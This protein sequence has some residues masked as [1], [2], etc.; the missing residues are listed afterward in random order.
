MVDWEEEEE[1]RCIQGVRAEEGEEEVGLRIGGRGERILVVVGVEEGGV[2]LRGRR[3]AGSRFMEAV[4]EGVLERAIAVE[5]EVE[6]AKEARV[7]A[8]PA[9]IG[10]RIPR[11]FIEGLVE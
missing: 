1:H 8:T 4:W 7:E 5:V 10:I 9:D 6:A 11:V 2:G 3:G